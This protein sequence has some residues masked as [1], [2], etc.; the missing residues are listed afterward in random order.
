MHHILVCINID[1]L[2]TVEGPKHIERI[3][4]YCQQVQKYKSEEQNSQPCCLM[5]YFPQTISAAKEIEEER[6]QEEKAKLK[7]GHNDVEDAEENADDV[8]ENADDDD[9]LCHPS[10]IQEKEEEFG[11]DRLGRVRTCLW[12]LLEYPETSKVVALGI[13]L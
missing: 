11:E 7:A 12:D 2:K 13:C 1:A 4:I 9:P 5:K 10:F 8:E 6:K 3:M